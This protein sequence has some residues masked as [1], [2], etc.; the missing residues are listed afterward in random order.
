VTRTGATTASTSAVALKTLATF[1]GTGY[2]GIRPGAWLLTVTDNEIGW[3]SLAHAYGSPGN[4]QIST[5]GHCGKVGTI[6]TV[7]AAFGNRGVV[8][9]DFGTF[10]KSTGDGGIG[11]DW[12]L[13]SIKSQYQSLASPTMPVWGGPKGRYTQTGDLVGASA[14]PKASLV[15]DVVHYGH[16]TGIGTGGTPRTGAAI[17][18]RPTYF[19]FFGAITPGDSGSGSNVL[20]GWPAGSLRQAAGINTH[21][22]VD[23][24]LRTGL[25]T[26]AGTRVTQV[27]ASLANGQLV[28]YPVPARGL[29]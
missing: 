26:M 17:T 25:G 20:T 19:A 8:L 2:F 7:I 4:L 22:Y 3:C 10:T 5:A 16:G 15:Q 11:K 1:A 29:P 27:P 12:A 24:S 21:I 14:S 28:A 23:S 13:I 6:A 18:W 9:L